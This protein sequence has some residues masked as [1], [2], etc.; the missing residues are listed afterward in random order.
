[1]GPELQ[2]QCW[3]H[4]P[5]ALGP[6]GTRGLQLVVLVLLPSTLSALQRLKKLAW[7]GEPSG[8]SFLQAALSLLPLREGRHG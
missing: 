1:M 7:H 2:R 6:R 8:V 3:A 4:C 5:L